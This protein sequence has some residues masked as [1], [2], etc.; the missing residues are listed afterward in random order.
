MAEAEPAAAEDLSPPDDS[1][2]EQTVT[3]GPPA[4]E[5]GGILTVDGDD[6]TWVVNHR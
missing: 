2:T 5:A 1:R 4:A 6:G 3:S